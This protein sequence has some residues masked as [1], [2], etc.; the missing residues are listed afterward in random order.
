MQFVRF[1][2]VGL[3]AF[4]IDY[5]LMVFITEVFDIDPVIAAT[6]SYILSTIFNYFASMRFVFHHRDEL[7]RRREFFIFFGLAIVG[8]AIND[9]LLWIA[10][11]MLFIDYRIAKLGVAVIVTMWNFGSRKVLLDATV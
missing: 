7:S 8:L 1:A 4:A 10:T 11:D 5:A 9:V 2:C 3:I 6:V